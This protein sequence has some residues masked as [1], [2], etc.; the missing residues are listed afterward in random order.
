MEELGMQASD[1]HHDGHFS[2]SSM[3]AQRHSTGSKRVKK[4]CIEF[5]RAY[6]IFLTEI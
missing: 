1:K 6:G 2:H 5:I 3:H 4:F